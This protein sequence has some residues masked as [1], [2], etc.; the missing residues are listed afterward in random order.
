[1]RCLIPFLF[2]LVGCSS[3][4]AAPLPAP[5]P[6]AP[7]VNIEAVGKGLDVI[8]SRVAASVVVSRELIKDGKPGKADN[9][10][11]VA[12]SLLP[13]PSEGDLAYSRQRS[14]KASDAEYEA[15]RKKA[16][17][18]QK[19]MEAAWVKLEQQAVASKAALAA[20]DKRIEEL[21]A[22]I[23]RVKKDHATQTWTWVGAGIAVI[24]AL[25]TA[26][27]GPKIG[28]PLLL[29]GGF[30]GAVPFIIESEWFEYAAG[31]TLVISCGLGIW[32]LADR[33]KDAVNKK[34]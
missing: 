25:T 14:E 31:A 17:G 33:V 16:E 6:S 19:E 20:R 29:C 22:E 26:F 15:A 24:G 21:T 7:E 23:E 3:K 34:P 5:T 28:L 4:P 10:L 13:R 18:K 9:E 32:Y 11:S 8:D 30:C 2:L 12:Q 27:M 1:M